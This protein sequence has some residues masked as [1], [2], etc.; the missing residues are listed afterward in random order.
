MIV[1]KNMKTK[2]ILKSIAL[3]AFLW[4]VASTIY[5]TGASFNG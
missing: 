3:G 5:A 4:S 1:R 2:K